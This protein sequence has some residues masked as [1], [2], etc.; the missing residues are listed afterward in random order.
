MLQP[1]ESYIIRTIKN[2]EYVNDITE[3][4]MLKFI[5]KKYKEK[6]YDF[7]IK[8]KDNLI[9]LCTLNFEVEDCIS[10]MILQ[11]IPELKDC[12]KA[13]AKN[14]YGKF[15]ENKT[16]MFLYKVANDIIDEKV[17]PEKLFDRILDGLK[18][19][20]TDKSSELV[21]NLCV[22]N[23]FRSKLMKKY[24]LTTTIITAFMRFEK[25]MKYQGGTIIGKLLQEDNEKKVLPYVSD[26]LKHKRL[27][28]NNVEMI[29]GGGSNLVFKINGMVLKLGETRN[30]KYI[31]INHR[32]LESKERKLFTDDKDNDLFFL[33]IMNYAL[34][35]DITKEEAEELRED[36]IRQGLNWYDTKL[37]NC[38]VLQDW[39]TNDTYFKD[40]DKTLELATK[41]DNP[42][43][44]EQFSKRKRRV[45][46]IDNDYVDYISTKKG[47]IKK[48]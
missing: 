18:K 37:E 38:G 16:K 32:I 15:F 24:P 5:L 10:F 21:Y 42:Y 44:R 29:G 36:L 47:G 26:L 2:C 35:G 9:N 4:E 20:P 23:D 30:N 11:K 14:T 43:D 22:F 33:E 8:Y 25:E 7:L 13:I 46:L 27:N 41:I 12:T 40:A 17:K 31:F 45:V 19:E 39:D 28:V 34:T 3:T 48:L 1:R 6:D